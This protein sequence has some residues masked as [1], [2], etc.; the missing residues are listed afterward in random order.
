MQEIQEMLVESLGGEDT[1]EKEMATYSSILSWEIPG[2]EES[3][4][5]RSM[6][7]QR[8][9][10]DWAHTHTYLMIVFHNDYFFLNLLHMLID[11]S[12]MHKVSVLKWGKKGIF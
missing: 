3:G 5:L 1:L 7:L 2:T 9:R 10:Y 11:L 8:I 4:E 12:K 6:G